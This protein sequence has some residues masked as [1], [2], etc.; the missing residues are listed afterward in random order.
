MSGAG[1][2][3]AGGAGR[4][5]AGFA[6]DGAGRL[7]DSK[8]LLLREPVAECAGRA[9]VSAADEGARPARGR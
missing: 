9:K 7:L 1:R 2:Q 3:G 5:R 4:F 8:R 6:W